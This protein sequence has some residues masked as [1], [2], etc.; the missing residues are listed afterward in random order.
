M[1]N[2]EEDTVDYSH[3][4]PTLGE[5]L[6]SWEAAVASGQSSITRE[7]ATRRYYQRYP[8]ARR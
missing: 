5:W 1:D 8:E 3:L 6:Y 2:E 4:T 7:E